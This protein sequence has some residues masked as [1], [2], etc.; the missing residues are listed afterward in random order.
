MSIPSKISKL[1]LLIGSQPTLIG[2]TWE[3]SWRDSGNS[4]ISKDTLIPPLT[5]QWSI[6]TGTP[7]SA[8]KKFGYRRLLAS[9]NK[10]FSVGFRY[11]DYEYCVALSLEGSILYKVYPNYIE[12]NRGITC[13]SNGKMWTGAMHELAYAMDLET[14]ILTSLGYRTSSINS[15][16]VNDKFGIYGYGIG[17]TD[18]SENPRVIALNSDG[19]LRWINLYTGKTTGNPSLFGQLAVSGDTL[20]VPM[21]KLLALNIS[22]GVEKWS[23]GS[24]ASELVNGSVIYFG[25]VQ[26]DYDKVCV[27]GQKYIALSKTYESPRLY[28]FDTT[29]N[30]LYSISIQ[31]VQKYEFGPQLQSLATD[32]YSFIVNN[33]VAYVKTP[34]SLTA[35]DSL[36]N[37]IWTHSYPYWT[38]SPSSAPW[39]APYYPLSGNIILSDNT[40][41]AIHQDII[42]AYNISSGTE[43]WSYKNTKSFAFSWMIIAYNRLI[44]IDFDGNVSAFNK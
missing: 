33:K 38:Y 14:G 30:L 7:Q 1:E 39:N 25:K 31:P 12:G 40:L 35:I 37:K 4:C 27:V 16:V 36:G 8:D 18:S 32:L 23:K 15:Y 26:V 34:D 28:I 17:G 29:G 44:T 43:L 41:F 9:Q 2:D 10:I 3:N 21:C 22:N 19:S 24:Y 6:K 11:T 5:L 13:I 42:Y 20:Y